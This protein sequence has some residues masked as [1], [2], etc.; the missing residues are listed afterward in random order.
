VV[1]T[2]AFL[3][4]LGFT[5]MAALADW[6]RA[7]PF[8]ILCGILQD[9]A[10]KLTPGTPVAMSLS[11]A[12]VYMVLLFSARVTLRERAQELAARF[13]NVTQSLIL[14]TFF[15]VLA[16]MNGMVTFGLGLWRVPALSLFIY[17]LPIPAVLLGY[18]WL[19]REAQIEMLFRFYAA[20]TSVALVGT[21]LEYFDVHSRALGMVATPWATI[22][23]LPGLQIRML[24]GFYRAPDIMGWH[25]GTLASI[26]VIM[27]MRRRTMLHAWPWIAVTAWGFLN[28]ILSGRRKAVYMFAVFAAAFLWRYFRR[29]RIAEVITF[30]IVAAVMTG[31]V[32]R[33]MQGEESNVYARGT[34]TTSSE[35]FERLEGGLSGTVQQVGFLGAGLGTATQGTQHLTEGVSFGWQEGGLGKLA[36][37]LGIPGLLAAAIVGAV[38]FRLALRI[39]AHPDLPET[40]QVLR[41]GLFGLIAADIAT[42]MASAQAYSDPLLMLFSAFTVGLLLGTAMLDERAR[43]VESIVNHP[44]PPVRHAPEPA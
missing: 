44:A 4:L 25:A 33:L 5:A 6:R 32:Q 12:A 36:V 23:H 37:E 18:A 14:F 30:L 27:A 7:W 38:L 34:A 17:L 39:S 13:T 1:F 28:C 31:V 35:V 41:A 20:V 16:A 24:S 42:F 26:G 10:R 11:I 8:V 9:P 15:L 3:A 40:S 19:N 21:I 22:R 2:A 29:L 43:D